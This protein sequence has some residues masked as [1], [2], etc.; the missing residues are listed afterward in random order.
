MFSLVN[1][2]ETFYAIRDGKQWTTSLNI[3]EVFGIPHD[4]VLKRIRNCQ[5]SEGFRLVNFHETFYAIRDGKQW[6]TSLNIAEV[7]G[8]PH[9][10]VLEKIDNCPCSLDFSRR[11]FSPSD[12]VDSRGKT[13]RCFDLTRDGFV[14]LA[15]GFI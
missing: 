8:K 1:F 3:A 10:D 5:C 11:N 13:Q 12:Y 4:E 15:M 7:F 14:L 2:H 9:K 6:T